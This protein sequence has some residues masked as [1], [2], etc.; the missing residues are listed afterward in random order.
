MVKELRTEYASAITLTSQ[1]MSASM[2]ADPSTSLRT[3]LTEA[4]VK[5]AGAGTT[6]LA[7]QSLLE[8]MSRGL[9]DAL[10]D[11]LDNLQVRHCHSHSM[12]FCF[13]CGLMT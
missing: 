4:A 1:R 12:C 2:A 5:M 8:S 10:D 6:G 7:Q 9:V 3:T 13:A 11:T